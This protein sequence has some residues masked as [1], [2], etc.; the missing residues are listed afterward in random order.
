MNARIVVI[1]EGIASM[2][3]DKKE[4]ERLTGVPRDQDHTDKPPM[5]T[6]TNEPP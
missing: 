5:S 4:G 1:G 2:F 6:K 3:P